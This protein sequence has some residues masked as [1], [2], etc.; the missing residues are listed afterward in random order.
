MNVDISSEEL[1]QICAL[2]S[3]APCH[4]EPDYDSEASCPLYIEC[5]KGHKRLCE[6]LINM[7]LR[8]GE[9]KKLAQT[10]ENEDEGEK[11]RNETETK[12]TFTMSFEAVKKLNNVLLSFCNEFPID[13]AC[14]ECPLSTSDAKCIAKVFEEVVKENEG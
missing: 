3:Y 8:I 11:T 7:L 10:P 12:V 14:N 1:E 5:D 6:G 4:Y 9:V 2:L 13:T